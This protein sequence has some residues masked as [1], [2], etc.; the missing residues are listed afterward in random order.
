[1][2]DVLADVILAYV[3][4]AYVILADGILAVHGAGVRHPLLRDGVEGA[5]AQDGHLPRQAQRDR[6]GYA[7]AQPR[8]RAWADPADHGAQAGHGLPAIVDD[9]GD[10]RRGDLRMLA[11]IEMLR[12]GDHPTAVAE[13]HRGEG[14]RRVDG[15]DHAGPAS[16]ARSSVTQWPLT[17]SNSIV[18]ASSPG[19]SDLRI[20]R[21]IL[22]SCSMSTLPSPHSTTVTP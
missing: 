14:R 18:R 19:S 8:I 16:A 6:R 22:E 17:G 11:R 7:H 5:H 15:E 3:I 9:L 10:E 21:T 1:M 2:D 4:L 12:L 20:R 13:G